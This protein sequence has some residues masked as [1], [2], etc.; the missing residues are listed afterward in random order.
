[1]LEL[2]EHAHAEHRLLS[3]S[4]QSANADIVILLGA[5]MEVASKSVTSIYEPEGSDEALLRTVALLNS[6]DT[7]LIK[8]SRGM[9]LERVIE[10]LKQTKVLN[11]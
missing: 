3:S 2:G 10:M 11:Q 6:G 8:G 5:H 9:R 7:V 1:M 4:I